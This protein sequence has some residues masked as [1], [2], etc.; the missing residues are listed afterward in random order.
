M[1]LELGRLSSVP[2]LIHGE[3]RVPD[4]DGK[5]RADGIRFPTPLVLD[6]TARRLGATCHLSGAVVGEALLQCG[7]CLADVPFA[8]DAA[9]EARFAESESAPLPDHHWRPG[10][11]THDEEEEGIRLAREDLDVSFLPPGA[12]SIRLDEVVREQVMLE[13]PLR[14]LCRPDCPGLCPRCGGDLDRGACAC[15][16]EGTEGSGDVRLAALAEIRKKLD[17]Q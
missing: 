11:A 9:F 5:L 14:P 2:V 6:G 8:I 4:E 10:A 12:R 1:E 3:V 7:R 16:P 17:R 13:I 15:P